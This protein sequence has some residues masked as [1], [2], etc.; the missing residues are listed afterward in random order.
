MRVDVYI[1]IVL[2]VIASALVW[3][4]I[5]LTPM[6]TPLRAQDIIQDVRIVGVKHPGYTTP[7]Q[8]SLG[9]KESRLNGDWDSL[10]VTP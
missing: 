7:N 3:L 6:G 1:R 8:F 10:S 5:V 4:C 2:T 9:P